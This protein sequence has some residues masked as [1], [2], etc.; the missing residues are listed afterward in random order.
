MKKLTMKQKIIM[1][2]IALIIIVGAIVTCTV[3]LNFELKYQKTQKIELYLKSEFEIKD[4][5]EMTDEVFPGQPVMLQKVEVYEDT[6]AIT[7]TEITEEQKQSM[8]DKVNEKYGAELSA[9]SIEISTIPSTRGRDIIKPYIRPFV[10]AT[11]AVLVYMGIR[12]AK[13]GV[14][15]TLLK[16][17]GAL[18]VSEATLLG[19]IAITRIPAGRTS[20]ILGTLIYVLV[21]LAITAKFEKNLTTKKNEEE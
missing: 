13:L 4:I 6:V 2:I 11:I 10:I 5:K 8:I 12:Y 3:G 9:D 14:I 1:I 17:F 20:I 19:I 15:K 7:T 18:V 16:T 21:L